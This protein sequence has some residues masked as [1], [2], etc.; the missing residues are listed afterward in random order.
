MGFA[1]D[2][3]SRAPETEPLDSALRIILIFSLI[4]GLF[5]RHER[6]DSDY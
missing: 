4:F 6:Y 2:I 5:L 1:S 3:V